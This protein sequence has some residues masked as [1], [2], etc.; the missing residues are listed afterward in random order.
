MPNNLPDRF[1][2]TK[3]IHVNARPPHAKRARAEELGEGASD[4]RGAVR[5]QLEVD[6]S[7]VVHTRARIRHTN[8]GIDR[9]IAPLPVDVGIGDELIREGRFVGR[10]GPTRGVTYLRGGSCIE[11]EARARSTACS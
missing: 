8:G 10:S 11:F 4:S 3:Q 2:T 9:D 7:S 6:K 5:T 1:S